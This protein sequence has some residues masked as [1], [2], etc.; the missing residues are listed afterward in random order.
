[1]PTS[2]LAQVTGILDAMEIKYVETPNN[3]CYFDMRVKD[4]ESPCELLRIY[5]SAMNEAAIF[6]VFPI[7]FKVKSS[8]MDKVLSLISKINEVLI[9]GC[10]RVIDTNTVT[11]TYSQFIYEDA[12]TERLLNSIISM[13]LFVWETFGNG[14]IPV[15]M[16]YSDDPDGAFKYCIARMHNGN[17][18]GAEDA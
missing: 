9:T 14:I 16:G 3:Q 17:S 5:V 6:D 18:K 11:F 7:G 2:V 8:A 4:A 10:Y 15:M 13:G 12:I 1:M